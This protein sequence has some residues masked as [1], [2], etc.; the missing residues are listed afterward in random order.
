MISDDL[1]AALSALDIVS[2][3]ASDQPVRQALTSITD[4]IAD[5]EARLRCME[6]GPIPPH[7]RRQP[8]RPADWPPNVTALRRGMI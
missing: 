6:V 8:S 5:C 7:W 3:V 1:R 2:R 4:T